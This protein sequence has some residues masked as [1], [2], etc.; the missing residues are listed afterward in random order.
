[1][2][3]FYIIANIALA[4]HLFHGIFSMFSSLGINSPKLNPLRRP[5]AAGIALLILLGN[6][7]FPIM[8]Q[9]GVIE[10]DVPLAV[11]IAQEQSEAAE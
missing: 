7:S 3:I 8:V 5:I 6:L 1:M 2:A 4:V 9:A 10:E 11:L